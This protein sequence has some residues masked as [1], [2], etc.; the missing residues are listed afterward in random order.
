MTT[1]KE[2]FCTESTGE[3]LCSLR[4]LNRSIFLILLARCAMCF[5]TPEVMCAEQQLSSSPQNKD[6][7]NNINF[8]ADSRFLVFDTREAGI[9]NCRTIEKVDVRTGEITVVYR[10]PDPVRDVGP[11]VGAASFLPDGDVIF[12][13]GLGSTETLRYDQARRFGAIAAGDGSGRMR[14]LDSRDATP[15]FTPGAL[16]GGTHKHE[17]DATGRWIGFTY[18]DAI[19]KFSGH[20]DLRNVGVARRGM[21]V[22]VDRDPAGRNLVGESF[23]VLVTH[24]VPDPKPGSDE[25]DRACWDCWVGTDGYT[26][27]DGTRGRARAFVG[28]VRVLEEGPDGGKVAKRYGDVFIVDIPEDITRPGPLGPLEGTADAYPAPPAGV[29]ERRLTRT[30]EAADPALRGVD[31]QMLRASPDG[32]WIAFIGKTKPKT[33]IRGEAVDKP[34]SA[35]RNSQSPI[36]KQ[37]F[38]VSPRGGPPRQVTGVHGGVTANYR[39]HASG[40]WV[41]CAG[42]RNEILAVSVDQKLFGKTITLGL[43]NPAP[44]SNIV[45]SPDGKLVACNRT[46]DG[47]KQIVLVSWPGLSP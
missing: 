24:A 26:R 7:D 11:G 31:E 22:E 28:Y 23:A 42:P 43:P 32:Q 1:E 29:S 34:K 41:V 46:I 33:T 45:C 17:P 13:H 21:R 15:P 9:E 10:A 39:W 18:N 38:I 20:S 35:I 12:I 14:P 27:P 44:V 2:G 16:R 30:A 6:L 8:S 5:G 25:Y 3:P 19:L 4:L 40:K 37:V 47:V 36:E